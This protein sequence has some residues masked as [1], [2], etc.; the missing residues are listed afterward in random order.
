MHVSAVVLVPPDDPVAL[1]DGASDI[2]GAPEYGSEAVT[3]VTAIS[4][5]P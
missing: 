4:S 1:A 2:D 5:E 3:D